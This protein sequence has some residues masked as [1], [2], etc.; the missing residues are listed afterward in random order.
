[1]LTKQDV[2]DT[3]IEFYAKGGLPGYDMN[4]ASCSYFADDGGRCAVGV[5]LE[6]LNFNKGDVEEVSEQDATHVIKHLGDRLTS[7]LED[8]VWKC[9][10]PEDGLAA[11]RGVFL[12]RLQSAHDTIADNERVYGDDDDDGDAFWPDDISESIADSLREFGA[13]EGL[14]I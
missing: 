11:G 3:V 8:N 6:K 1:M 5:L 2:L 13:R 4:F 9:V 12:N 7:K 14:S 10:R